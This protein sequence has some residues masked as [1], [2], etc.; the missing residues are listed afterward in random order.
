MSSTCCPKY[1]RHPNKLAGQPFLNRAVA[2]GHVPILSKLQNVWRL[3]RMADMSESNFLPNASTVSAPK[4]INWLFWMI[5]NRNLFQNV[6][7][8]QFSCNY[9]R[10]TKMPYRMHGRVKPIT[11]IHP[12]ERPFRD[13]Q[14]QTSAAFWWPFFRSASSDFT[15]FISKNCCSFRINYL[16]SSRVCTFSRNHGNIHTITVRNL[17]RKRWWRS[18]SLK[19]TFFW[20]GNFKYSES[21]WMWP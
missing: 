18:S 10:P 21:S 8:C 2:G 6:E 7:H 1:C 11:I 13:I 12:R 5:K 14:L 19:S 16:S 17:K 9:S 20:A 4:P 3:R 15:R